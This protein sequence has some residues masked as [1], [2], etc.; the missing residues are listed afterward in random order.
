MW[1]LVIFLVLLLSCSGIQDNSIAV[2]DQFPEAIEIIPFPFTENNIKPDLH[3]PLCF[4]DFIILGPNCWIIWC[5][6]PCKPGDYNC[7]DFYCE[8]SEENK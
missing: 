5:S 8:W 4:R 3:V 2:E 7:F 1:R 6:Y